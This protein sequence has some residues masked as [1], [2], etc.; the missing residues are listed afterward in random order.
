MK[1]LFLYVFSF[2]VGIL[3]F[4]QFCFVPLANW[5]IQHY[6]AESLHEYLT[7]LVKGPFYL[8]ERELFRLP[9]DQ[10]PEAVREIDS[11]FGFRVVMSGLDEVQLP[12]SARQMLEQGQIVVMSDGEYFYRR[13]PGSDRALVLGPIKDFEHV[14]VE[15]VFWPSL[16]LT[17]AVFTAVGVVPLW[18]HIRELTRTAESFGKGHL[19][20]QARIPRHSPLFPFA[21]T[22]NAMAARI[23]RLLAS[24]KMLINAVSHEFRTPISRICFGLEML[25]ATTREARDRHL[26]GIRN[27][28]NELNGLVEELLTYAKLDGARPELNPISVPARA[29][30]DERIGQMRMEPGRNL[31]ITARSDAQEIMID[32]RLMTR[33]VDNLLQNA[34]RHAGSSIHIELS[35]DWNQDVIMRVED[36]GPGIAEEDRER[37]FEPFE[38]VDSSRSRSDG[39]YGLGLAIVRQVAVWHGGTAR[40]EES[41][42][43]GACFEVRWPQPD[44]PGL[45]T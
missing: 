29:W 23:D 26:Q 6:L 41:A 1:R 14:S 38:R 43:G 21:D 30:L 32:A 40:A 22:F 2:V 28:V 13:L 20:V 33:A 31:R 25:D 4:L 44:A 35:R 45:R 27:D 36:D 39:G 7:D 19:W 5:C 16:M 8:L 34:A 18:R 3:L 10:W 15:L 11:H 37:I 17:L 42:L 12:P 9:P 24:H